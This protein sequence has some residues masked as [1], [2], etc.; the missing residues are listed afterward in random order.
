M[1]YHVL[2][3]KPYRREKHK[4]IVMADKP[5]VL[6]KIGHMNYNYKKISIPVRKKE[7]RHGNL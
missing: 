5:R 1:G 3:G 4:M 2:C 7:R 6:V